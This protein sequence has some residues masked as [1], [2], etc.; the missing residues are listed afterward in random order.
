MSLDFPAL[1]GFPTFLL[2]GFPA[3]LGLPT[4]LLPEVIL[5]PPLLLVASV[6]TGHF[7][8]SDQFLL[9]DPDFL[10]FPLGE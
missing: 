5:R 6:G 8:D 2:L 9:V 1:L 10:A 7:R 3:L 4:F